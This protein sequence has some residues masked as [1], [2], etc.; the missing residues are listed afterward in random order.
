MLIF[1]DLF[2]D[3]ITGAIFSLARDVCIDSRVCGN[4]INL[5]IWQFSLSK[6][7]IGVG[8]CTYIKRVSVPACERHTCYILRKIILQK[9]KKT[10]AQFIHYNPATAW[11]N[12]D[13]IH[14]PKSNLSESFVKK[15][16]ILSFLSY[17]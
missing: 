17:Q 10:R 11:P 6:V 12:G 13:C 8:F 2:Q 16:Q 14:S 9:R 4:F 1:L 15:L 3:L 5:E 7:L